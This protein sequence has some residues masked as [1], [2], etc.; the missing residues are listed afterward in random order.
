MRNLAGTPLYLAPELLDGKEASVRSDIYALGVLLYHLLTG[1]Y[2]VVGAQKIRDL[3]SALERGERVDL[4]KLR[5]DVPRKSLPR[6]SS[7]RSIRALSDGMRAAP[8]WRPICVRRRDDHTVLMGCSVFARARRRG[9]SRGTGA[10]TSRCVVTSFC[11]SPARLRWPARRVTSTPVPRH[12]RRS[13][14]WDACGVCLVE[15]ERRIR[16]LRQGHGRGQDDADHAAPWGEKTIQPG[17]RMDGS[18]RSIG[19]TATTPAS[20]PRLC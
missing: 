14:P 20:Q 3:Q 19:W 1:V 6:S 9:S 5:S 16:D 2:P 4:R 8:R 7:A 18:W 11:S 10:S 12:I 17:L 15:P 13:R